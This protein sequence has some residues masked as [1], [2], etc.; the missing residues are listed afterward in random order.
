MAPT[1][2]SEATPGQIFKEPQ[3][4]TERVE[5][6]SRA[7]EDPVRSLREVIRTQNAKML[8]PGRGFQGYHAV[9]WAFC[10]VQQIPG[11]AQDRCHSRRRHRAGVR[12]VAHPRHV[13]GRGVE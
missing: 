6:L 9:V 4:K 7:H 3:I 10:S 5:V 13:R 12:E 8:A 11:P 1:D 2:A